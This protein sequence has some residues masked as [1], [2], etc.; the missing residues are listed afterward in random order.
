MRF[1][2]WLIAFC[3]SRAAPVQDV[4]SQPWPEDECDANDD[5]CG[6]SLRQLRGQGLEQLE[7]EDF[8]AGADFDEEEAVEVANQT[9][10]E[11][12]FY[13]YRA[14]N[15]KNYEDTN[16][17]MANLPGVMWYLHSEVVGHCPR[18]FGIVRILRY[19][20]TMKPT[21][22]LERTGHPFAHLC[23]FDSGACTGP[24]QSLDEYQ[25]YGYVVGCDRPNHQHAAYRQATWYSFPGDC[26]SKTFQQK[27]S[28][29]EKGGLCKHGE[30]WSK[31][32]TWRR[33]YAGEITLD[34]LTHNYH[35][36]ERC[37][38]GFYE[39]NEALDRG[40]GTNYWHTRSSEAVCNRRMKW[41][42][43]VL[44]RKL[45]AHVSQT[46][47]SARSETGTA[48]MEPRAAPFALTGSA[49][50]HKVTRSSRKLAEQAVRE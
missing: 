23:H 30:P 33:E 19:K 39:Y 13:A 34:E 6:L 22:E 11:Y 29:Q 5:S 28:C 46:L 12:S 44:Q 40:Q 48:D 50:S 20:I 25:K 42:K 43:E 16:V 24:Q 17:N 1:S 27:A 2:V 18:K 21:P 38:K 36:E 37:K 47:H 15:D 32:C 9:G 4:P 8:L 49:R 45:A 35:F 7:L 26:P 14:K 41:L 31:T 10:G 3:L